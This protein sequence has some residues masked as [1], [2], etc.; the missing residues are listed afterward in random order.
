[1]TPSPAAPE[2]YEIYDI[3]S[4]HMA[5]TEEDIWISD[6]EE[7]ISFHSMQT[8]S[9]DSPLNSVKHLRAIASKSEEEFDFSPSNV[10]VGV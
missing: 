9:S 1:M 8:L 6:I 5:D 4:S 2:V 3:S 7:K 10:V